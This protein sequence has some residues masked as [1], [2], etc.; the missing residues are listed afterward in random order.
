MEANFLS[1]AQRREF[2]VKA[3]EEANRLQTI[4]QLSNVGA[5]VG[6]AMLACLGE[7]AQLIN[8]CASRW[9]LAPLTA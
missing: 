7:N 8:G 5:C 2:A 3:V 1:I 9:Q 4:Q 6:Y